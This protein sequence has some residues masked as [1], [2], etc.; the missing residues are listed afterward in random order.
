MINNNFVTITIALV[1]SLALPI[2]LLIWWKRRTQVRL[3]PFI[4]GAICFILF[5]MVF[6]QTLHTVCLI[7]DNPVSRFIN[8]SNVAYMLYGALA[9]GIFEETGRMFGFKVFLKNDT[10]KETSVAYGIGHGGIEVII[11][12]GLTYFM[13]FLAKCGVIIGTE[14]ATKTLLS[15]ADAIQAGR[16][17]TAMFERISAMMLHIGL[18][19]IVFTAARDKNKLW[20]YPLAV[21]LHAAVDAPAALVQRGLPIPVWIIEVEAFVMGIICIIIGKKMLDGYDL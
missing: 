18:S 17:F 19:M 8:G 7:L 12:L 13:F 9:A 15:T 2:G 4:A 10:K 16:V 3:W 20:H 6:E 1:Y 11:I 14:E 5:A 21:L